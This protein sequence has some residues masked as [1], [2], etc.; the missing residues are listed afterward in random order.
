MHF[1]RLTFFSRSIPDT[2]IDTTVITAKYINAGNVV[3]MAS[4]IVLTL[5][6]TFGIKSPILLTIITI[7]MNITVL[8]TPLYFLFLNAVE[9]NLMAGYAM[10]CL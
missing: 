3:I 5:S 4:I 9:L 8:M 6:Y 7:T 2:N 1:Y 10:E